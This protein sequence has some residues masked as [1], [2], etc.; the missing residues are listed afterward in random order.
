[1]LKCTKIQITF[2]AFSIEY[3]TEWYGDS[4]TRSAFQSQSG[5][6][7]DLSDRLWQ[8][9]VLIY[10]LFRL[11]R[12]FLLISS[13]LFVVLPGRFFSDFQQ[14]FAQAR[15]LWTY[16]VRICMSAC[17]KTVL[18]QVGSLPD[19]FRVA[20]LVNDDEMQLYRWEM[21]R[22]YKQNLRHE[23]NKYSTGENT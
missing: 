23:D 5:L 19:A 18:Y 7:F 11:H 16:A 1:M 17:K 12:R 14:R 21:F 10:R 8:V 2:C 15:G 9:R 3:C 4:L 20:W 6:L 13:H 22:Q